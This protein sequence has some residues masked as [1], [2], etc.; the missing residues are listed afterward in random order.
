MGLKS[1]YDLSNNT[2]NISGQNIIL[3][4]RTILSNIQ[5]IYRNVCITQDNPCMIHEIC[6]LTNVH[7]GNPHPHTHFHHLKECIFILILNLSRY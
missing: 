6:V 7:T 4:A 1:N 2:G 5:A 3:D